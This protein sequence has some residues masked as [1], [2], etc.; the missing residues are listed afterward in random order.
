MLSE[1]LE[2][3]VKAN[4]FLENSSSYTLPTGVPYIGMGSSYFAPLAFK[5]MGIDIYP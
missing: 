2:M 5:Y 1:I 4:H 3:P